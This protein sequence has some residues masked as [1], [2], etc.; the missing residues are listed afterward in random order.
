MM[1]VIWVGR[2][3]GKNEVEWTGNAEIRKTELLAV[4]EGCTATFWRGD[5]LEPLASQQR[6]LTSIPPLSTGFTVCCIWGIPP[7]ST[8]FTVCCIWGI[9]PLST[10]FTVCCIWGIPPI[11]T[12]SRATVINLQFVV[13]GYFVVSGV[14]LST[15]FTFCCIWGISKHTIYILLYLGYSATKYRIDCCIWG[16][17]PLGT[18]FSLLYLGYSTTKHRQQGHGYQLT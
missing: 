6:G 17:P 1:H 9:L 14:S 12:G 7:L 10:R 15:Q 11:S 16:I 13:A 3:L 8:G 2:G 4:Y 18:G 5:P